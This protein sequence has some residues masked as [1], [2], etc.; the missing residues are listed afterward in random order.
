[1][2]SA[3]TLLFN[4]KA[5]PDDA[6]ENIGRFRSLFSTNIGQLG[7]QL[8]AWSK[9]VLGEFETVKGAMLGLTAAAAGVAVAIGAGLFELVNK[10]AEAGEQFALLHQQ[11]GISVETLSAMKLVAGETGVAFE[12]LVRGVEIMDRGLSPFASSGATA[13]KAMQALGVSA[14]DAHGHLRSN[15]DLLADLADKFSHMKDGAD[16][17]AAAMAIFGRSGAEMIPILD[18]GGDAIRNATDRASQMGIAF[19]DITAEQSVAF[20][21]NLRDLKFTAEG[22]AVAIGQEMMPALTSAVKQGAEF[23]AANAGD[24]ASF[25]SG[26]MTVGNGIGDIFLAAWDILKAL[27][28]G[29]AMIIF[30]VE[31]FAAAAW[32]AAHGHM[33]DAKQDLQAIGQAAQ[34]VGQ[35]ELHVFDNLFH[36]S[37]AATANF[38]SLGRMLDGQLG[39][40]AAAAAIPADKLATALASVQQ[41]IELLRDQASK[42]VAAIEAQFERAVASANA[43]LAAD[44]KLYAAK[45]ISLDELDH[46]EREHSEL[47]TDLATQRNLKLQAAEQD[48]AQKVAELDLALQTKLDTADKASYS[49]RLAMVNKE[50]EAERKKYLA[51]D[52][53]DATH[54]ELLAQLRAQGIIA[55]AKAIGDADKAE[56]K[57]FAEKYQLLTQVTEQY[58]AASLQGAARVKYEE[59]QE[60]QRIDKMRSEALLLAKTDQERAQVAQAASAAIVAARAK[61]QSQLDA[62]STKVSSF[63]VQWKQTYQQMG[64]VLGQ[65]HSTFTEIGKSILEGID[66]QIAAQKTQMEEQ[67]RSSYSMSEAMIGALKQSAIVQAIYQTAESIAA[68]ASLDFRAGTM[69]ALAAAQYG[70]VAGAQIASLV[71]GGGGGSRAGSPQGGSSAGAST[72]STAATGANAQTLLNVHLQGENFSARAV[73]AIMQQINALTQ[74]GSQVL[75]ATHFT[76]AGATMVPAH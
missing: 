35:Q 46:R 72:G 49:A 21:E 6:V 3:A 63:L 75:V 15:T 24:I 28:Q 50:V 69:H 30:T 58:Y 31:Q 2:D 33:H 65:F 18:K 61:E 36:S 12:T 62:L 53:L 64:Q 41:A 43:E 57:K 70:L 10:T 32:D 47:V 54:E 39:P 71:G 67:T 25:I 44:K 40:A 76:V 52:S 42:P 34:E 66:Q 68:F 29:L 17:T 73:A 26:L 8:E 27:G 13:A 20:L 51:L 19:T 16:K 48:R 5:N 37:T 74:S 9:E 60:E 23:L 22:V 56:E 14:T 59:Q 38:A 1:M 55:A 4:I 45:K 7:T 11:T